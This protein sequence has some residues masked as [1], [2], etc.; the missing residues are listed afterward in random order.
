[1][2][3]K[4]WSN[5]CA[6]LGVALIAT[7]VFQDHWGWGVFFGVIIASYGAHLAEE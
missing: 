6:M 1:M 7:A 3:K 2:K 5:L 4:Y